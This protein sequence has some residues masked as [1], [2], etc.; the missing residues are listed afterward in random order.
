MEPPPSTGEASALVSDASGRP[1]K[2]ATILARPQGEARAMMIQA[3][4]G[5]RS[6]CIRRSTREPARA[7]DCCRPTLEPELSRSQLRSIIRSLV[8][9]AQD[10]KRHHREWTSLLLCFCRCEAAALCVPPPRAVCCRPQSIPGFGAEHCA[11]A[12]GWWFDD[13]AQPWPLGRRAA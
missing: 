6:L 4:K 2:R 12:A 9:E 13:I 7:C 10:H 3:S 1:G 11:A 5:G 8:Q